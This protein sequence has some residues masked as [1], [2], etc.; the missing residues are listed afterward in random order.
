[1]KILRKRPVLV[2]LLLAYLLYAAVYIFRSSV[3]AGGERYFVLFDDAMISMR[4][5]QHLAAGHGLVWNI[6][7][8]PVEGF[9]NPLWV[10]YMAI[11]HL[12][13]I[14]LRLTSL[15]I[16]LSGALFMAGTLVF[17]YLLVEHYTEN[18]LGPSLA[19]LVTAAYMPLNNWALQGMEVSLLCLLLGAAVWKALRD[20]G[21]AR[22][23]VWPYVLLT[24]GVWTRTDMAVPM[25][26]LTAVLAFTDAAHRRQH[27][28]WGVGLLVLSLGLQ[29]ALRQAYFGA[30]LPNTYY[31]KLAGT[32]LVLR[33]QRGLYT[34]GKFVYEFNWVLFVLPLV[35]L[36]LHWE[37]GPWLWAL[38]FA[39]QI[40]YSIYVGG[41]A[42][43]S[44]GGANRYLSVAIPLYFALFAL[45]L[46]DL[47]RWVRARMPWP[48]LKFL[49][50]LSVI[51]FTLV[52]LVNMNYLLQQRQSL[53]R[54]SLLRPP[55]FTVVSEEYVRMARALDKLTAPQA[56]VAVVT[57]GAISYFSE[58]PTI[59]LLGK[60]DAYVARLPIH[61][62]DYKH[63][64]PGHMKYD[65]DYSIGQ[66]KP[67]VI[68]QL[69]GENEPAKQYMKVDYMVVEIDGLVLSARSDSPYIY[70]EQ[71]DRVYKQTD[72][73]GGARDP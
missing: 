53:E 7:E 34:F 10:G 65:Y 36:L 5:A 18:A 73:L 11:F 31:L 70:W 29:T 6:G 57:A 47:H 14:P 39:G 63:L 32:P 59:D 61:D 45:T 38:L 55:M 3:V 1:M 15:F 60:S 23:S 26:T 33:V 28:T 71:A 17:V 4:Y 72:P 69:W 37:R 19:V 8:A 30:P 20:Q 41:D 27:V 64:R 68:V 16:Q 12:F 25:L 9:T 50:A 67:D 52:G 46:D 48:R 22:F 51:G 62:A 44:K 13:P 40:A 66:L 24:L 21:E 56:R 42:W 43:E 54:L 2:L 35:A 49:V 58:R